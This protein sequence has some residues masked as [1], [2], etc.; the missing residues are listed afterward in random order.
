M[1]APAG[2]EPGQGVGLKNNDTQ[3]N[4]V[5]R[6]HNFGKVVFLFVNGI[7]MDILLI[8]GIEKSYP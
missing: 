7:E 1:F 3:F 2:L 5:K 8:N 4:L 6:H